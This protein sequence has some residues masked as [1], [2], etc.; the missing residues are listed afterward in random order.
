[1]YVI[2][3]SI[4]FVVSTFESFYHVSFSSALPPAKRKESRKASEV[5]KTLSVRNKN[6]TDVV[7]VFTI[8]YPFLYDSL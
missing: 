3:V 5:Q 1:M 6:V 7:V 8:S 4:Y 2:P